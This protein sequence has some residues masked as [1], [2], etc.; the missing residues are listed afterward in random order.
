MNLDTKKLFVVGLALCLSTR[1]GQTQL[2]QVP[3]AGPATKL[4]SVLYCDPPNDQRVKVRMEG[5]EMTPLPETK[6][7]VKQ[8]TVRL[9]DDAGKLEAVVEAPQCIYAPMEG[10]ANSSGHLQLRLMDDKIHVEGDG[11]VWK[12]GDNSLTISNNVY[13]VI[14]T[15]AWNLFTP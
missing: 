2:K 15:G 4:S 12:Q 11:F 10:A 9:F 1:L 8:L 5:A 3:L 14:K 7:N 13:T 6:F